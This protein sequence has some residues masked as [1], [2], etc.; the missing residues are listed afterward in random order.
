MLIGSKLE[1]LRNQK[2]YTQK[3]FAEKIGMTGSGYQFAVN[4]NDFKY[5]TLLN[6]A[7]L[8]NITISQLVSDEVVTHDSDKNKDCASCQQKDELISALKQTIE[9]KEELI[10]ALKTQLEIQQNLLDKRAAS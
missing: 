7:K 10:Q 4:K 9:A 6:A 5:S 1:Y 8:C 2:N 3:E